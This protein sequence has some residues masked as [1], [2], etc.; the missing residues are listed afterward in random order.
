VRVGEPK[1]LPLYLKNQGQYP[2]SFDFKMKKASTRQIFTITPMQGKLEP[3]EDINI[4]VRFLSQQEKKMDKDK[5]AS[6]ITM[7]ILEGEQN[8]I[9]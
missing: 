8:E 3:N 9:H 5:H 7:I 2:I 1:E 4:N 6:D